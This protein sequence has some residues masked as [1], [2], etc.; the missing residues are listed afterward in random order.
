VK[1]KRTSVC[2][3]GSGVSIKTRNLTKTS[4]A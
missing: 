3:A 2:V 1:R 4:E